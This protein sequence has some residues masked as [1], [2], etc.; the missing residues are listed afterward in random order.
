MAGRYGLEIRAATSADAP[1]LAELF[2]SVGPSVAPRLLAERLDVVLKQPGVVL[3]A[4]EWGPPSG[5][6]AVH[7][8]R[9]LNADGP[10]A[11]VDHLLVAPDARRRG[12][13]RLLLKA[14][15][16]S[17]RSAR[18]A[19]LELSTDGGEITLAAFCEATGFSLVGRDYAR[20]LR[21][22]G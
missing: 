1:G 15:A 16:Q 20:P 10:V 8:R 19:T 4:S 22:G 9:T 21:K 11:R 6:I 2:A 14:A 13:G 5:A 12:I 3:I 18:C 7:W 17:A